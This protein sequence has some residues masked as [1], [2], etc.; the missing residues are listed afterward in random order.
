MTTYQ[1]YIQSDALRDV[2]VAV[3]DQ[4][5][6]AP[7]EYLVTVETKILPLVSFVWLGVFLMISAMLPMLGMEV[8]ALHRA[9]KGKGMD[10]YEDVPEDT[11]EPVVE[12]Q[13]R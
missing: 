4:S 7:N 10:L 8:Q 9:F 2:Y 1:V 13:D 3:T 11:D 6:I 12:T 5:Q